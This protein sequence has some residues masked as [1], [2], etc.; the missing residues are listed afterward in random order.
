MQIS[1]RDVI[2]VWLLERGG[3]NTKG[4]SK[5]KTELNVRNSGGI[6]RDMKKIR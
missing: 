4:W 3:M 2:G 5:L 6:S 1:S